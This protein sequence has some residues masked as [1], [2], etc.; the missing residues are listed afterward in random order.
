[1]FG[2]KFR[3][4]SLLA[5]AYLCAALAAAGIARAD[6]YDAA[7]A[8]HGRSVLDLK[9]DAQDHPANIMRL[10]GIKPGMHV[11]DVL[12]GDGYYSELL[13]YAVGPEGKVLMLNN[14]TFDNWA[15]PTLAA[16]LAP[17]RLPNVDHHAVDLAHMHLAPQSLDAIFLVKVYHDLY[18]SDPQ[19]IW[20]K[21]DAGRVLDQLA[22]ALKPAGVLVV[23]DH[24]AKLGTGTTDASTLHRIDEGYTIAEFGK[25]GLE[26]AA[27]ST[28]LR[29]ADDPREQ[30]SFK[31][32]MV[33][34]TDRFVIVFRKAGERLGS[35]GGV[36]G[37]GIAGGGGISVLIPASATG[38][39]H[40]S[41][42]SAARSRVRR[43]TRSRW[44]CRGC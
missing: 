43:G 27:R 36:S 34:N 25:R 5:C 2:S 40:P 31:G 18:W 22:R 33:S 10:A 14:A 41:R 15:G 32:S 16:R 20:P 13:S 19:G 35:T 44:E 30:V 26:V 6:E 3:N 1:M 39:A 4:R 7:V 28:V 21:I 42:R 29:R 9:R 37:A 38:P 17:G 11:A 23:V 12:A 8:H 24:S